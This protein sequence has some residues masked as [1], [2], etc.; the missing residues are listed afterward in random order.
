MKTVQPSADAT[1]QVTEN[2]E[3]GRCEAR[4]LPDEEK[5]KLAMGR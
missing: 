4:H 1:L 3:C 5:F 2:D